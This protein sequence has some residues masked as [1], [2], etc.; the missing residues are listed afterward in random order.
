M[1]PRNCTKRE[2]FV[3]LSSGDALTVAGS[4]CRSP[5]PW[6]CRLAVRHAK[7][8]EHLVDV[9]VLCVCDAVVRPVVVDGH[10]ENP[11]FVMRLHL[12]TCAQ[13]LLE[14]VEPGDVVA[15][16][17]HVVDTYAEYSETS[18]CAIHERAWVGAAATPAFVDAPFGH[19]LCPSPAGLAETTGTL[20]KLIY[21]TGAIV[22]TL[23]LT[24]EDALV[25][26]RRSVAVG[27]H[28]VGL[29]EV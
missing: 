28:G 21:T 12:E 25:V 20:G 5:R 2:R 4:A 23:E 27:G 13:A 10:T 7:P 29:L 14:L 9:G 3:S 18:M 1:P 16:E 22:E 6:V 24:H 26:R 15:G 8:I 11:R 19:K 17:W